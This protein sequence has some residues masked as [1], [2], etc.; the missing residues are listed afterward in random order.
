MYDESIFDE[1]NGE[2]AMLRLEAENAV[3]TFE[4]KSGICQNFAR[5]LTAMCR[6]VGIPT[7]CVTGVAAF[8]GVTQ[9]AVNSG[10]EW[11]EVYIDGEWHLVDATWGLVST[12]GKHRDPYTPEDELNWYVPRK[13][14]Y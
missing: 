14:E 10:H 2:K 9:D 5:L 1:V 4:T 3:K 8:N 12:I 7:R 11:N 6:A 13:Y